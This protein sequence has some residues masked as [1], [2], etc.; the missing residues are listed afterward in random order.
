MSGIQRYKQR[1]TETDM[2]TYKNSDK[3]RY[4]W[5]LWDLNYKKLKRGS[6]VSLDELLK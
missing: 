6:S 2:Q 1:Y 5:S 3:Q 4:L